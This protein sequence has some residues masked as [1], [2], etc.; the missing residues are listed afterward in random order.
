MILLWVTN[1]LK[2]LN[3]KLHISQLVFPFS[4]ILPSSHSIQFCNEFEPVVIEYLP[5]Q[6]K[7]ESNSF[8]LDK[9]N[10]NVFAY[11][12]SNLTHGASDKQS[13]KMQI[14]KII[15]NRKLAIKT[16][17]DKYNSLFST[18]FL[19]ISKVIELIKK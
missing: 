16:T 9:N 12:Y 18:D 4:L 6:N 15:N 19:K 8:L 17:Y 7:K 3:D 13:L 10:N 2:L 14:H 5:L 1:F 11:R